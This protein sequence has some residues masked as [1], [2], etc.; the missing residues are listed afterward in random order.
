M[1]TLV[2]TMTPKL[3]Q[4]P[5]SRDEAEGRGKTL[6]SRSSP[7]T[8]RTSASEGRSCRQCGGPIPGQRR[9]GFCSDACRMRSGRTERDARVRELVADVE[10]AVAALK[11]ELAG[12]KRC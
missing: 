11:S 10:R 5:Q 1:M 3:Q 8:T 12:A 9:N 7:R 4:R 2:D 6:T